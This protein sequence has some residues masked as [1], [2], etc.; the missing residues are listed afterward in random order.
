MDKDTIAIILSS[1]ALL[2]TGYN[3]YLQ[4]FKVEIVCYTE[5]VEGNLQLV[6]E[7]TSSNLARNYT[8]Q[9]EKILG[10]EK[11]TERLLKMPLL[12]RGVPFHLSSKKQLVIF[13]DTHSLAYMPDT[14]EF[15]KLTITIFDSKGKIK[16]VY[17]LNFDIYLNRIIPYDQAYLL[18]EEIKDGFDS[19]KTSI[20]TKQKKL[21][22]ES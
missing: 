14:K 13:V 19:I 15:P 18:R 6:I 21:P 10:N 11:L 1:I 5:M 9:V 22:V 4:Y 3:I 17:D 8:I 12:N 2:V 20:N 16:G 7:N